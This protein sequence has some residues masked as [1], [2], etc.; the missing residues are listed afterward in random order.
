MG[1]G[2][3]LIVTADALGQEAAR[4]A[5]ILRARREGVLTS[6]SLMV[7]GPTA[8]EAASQSRNDP[9][10]EVGLHAVLTGLAPALS[11]LEIPSLV[12]G[13]GR[14][15]SDLAALVAAKRDEVVEELRAQHRRF[16]RL[17]GR[18]PTHLDVRDHAHAQRA[19]FEAVVTLGWEMGVPIRAVSPAMRLHLRREG[20]Q[21]TDHFVDGYD[22]AQGFCRLLDGLDQGTTEVRCRAPGPAAPTGDDL[23][24]LA[25]DEVRRRIESLGIELTG[26]SGL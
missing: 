25:S 8:E 24:V 6:A 23:S 17:V 21:T 1:E 19:V 26:F 11:A 3:R 22:G 12:D 2:G 18:P 16:R 4:D 7:L 15:P 5:T 10:L 9:H 14:L 13:Q 20:L